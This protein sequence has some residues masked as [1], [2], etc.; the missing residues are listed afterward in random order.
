MPLGR[1]IAL[2]ALACLPLAA[3]AR[4]LR[5]ASQD[6]PQTLDP[7]SANL[8][9]TS[10]LT[11]NVYEPLV[12]RDKDWK[13]IP[14]LATSWT[15][16][17][18]KT[19]RFKLRAGVKFHDGSAFTA[20]DVVFSVERALSP[21]SQLKVALQGVEKAVKVDALTVDLVMREPNPVLLSHMTNFRIMSKA[22][23]VKNGAV[24]PQD[25]T[26]KEDTYAARNANGTG[27]FMVKE[28]Q[29]DVKT[30][31]VA[32]KDWW[33]H[34][35]GRNEGNLTEV[36]M[37]PI[38]SNATRLAALL[39]GEVDLV[40]DP[41]TQDVARLRADP[42][43]K[44][45]EGGELRVQYIA[46][47]VFRDDLLYGK[48]NG[49][50]P[51]KD[52][53]VRQAVAHAID[54]DAIRAKVMR[55]FSRPAGAILTP[56]VQGYSA[57]A[58]RRLP[59]DR[60]KARKLLAEA[61]YPNGFDVTLDAGN[62]QPAAD[63]AQAVA[64]MLS[65]VGINVRPNIVPQSNYFPKIEKYDTSFYVLSWGAGVTGDALYTLQALLHSVSRKGEGDFNM[66]RWSNA[67]MD[68]LIQQLQVESQ[69]AK[70][71]AIV[72]EA[73]LL[74]GR[75]LPIVTIHQPLIP[76]AMRR[77]VS[78]WFSPVNTVYFYRVRVD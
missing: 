35:A 65:Q 54:A 2:L 61:G 32:H 4:T 66:G 15:Q 50:N 29:T 40:I 39:S 13:V 57:D 34:A 19:W 22:W 75:E 49:K 63:I 23:S 6:D 46:F 51:F 27:A 55:G 31:L 76:W 44:I 10:R 38:K 42:G 53:R 16:P 12:W 60:D 11:S 58:D 18:A 73:L 7:H 52:I 9:S 77:N 68:E 14:W 74:A 72:R 25:Y 3:G 20:D 59:Y 70:R 45:V 71:D 37:L 48:A 24:R 41:P 62:I 67:R 47:D 33:G 30:V 56:G 5:Y 78:A 8:L 43:V 64:A 26:A 21:N 28:R 36:V 1:T 17:D 69:P